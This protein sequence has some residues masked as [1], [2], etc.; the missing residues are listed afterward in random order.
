VKIRKHPGNTS[1]SDI[2]FSY[3]E[4]L[5]LVSDLYRKKF[6]ARTLYLATTSKLY[7]KMG[8]LLKE[9]KRHREALRCF[10]HY[11]RIRPLHWK[12]WVRLAQVPFDY[13]IA[14]VKH[15]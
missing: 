5:R 13:M 8:L 2:L 3:P 12:G 10:L 6:V 15:E 1:A 14:L 9:N 11:F 4:T 7:Y